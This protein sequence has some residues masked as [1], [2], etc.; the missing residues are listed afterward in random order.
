MTVAFDAFSTSGEDSDDL[1]WTHTPSGTPKGVTVEI[2]Q[3]DGADDQVSGVTY[4]AVPMTRQAFYNKG[5]AGQDNDFAVYIYSL[6]SSVPT[7]AQ[8][9]AV[10]RSATGDFMVGYART[11]TT[12]SGDTE[13]VDVDGLNSSG[14]AG[15]NDSTLNLGGKTC[16]V[17]QVCSGGD[18]TSPTNQWT[19]LTGWTEDNETYVDSD[20]NVASFSYDT[21]GSSDVTFGADATP[22]TWVVAAI[23]IAEA[24][25]GGG[26]TVAATKTSMSLA[27][28][29]GFT[30][31]TFPATKASASLTAKDADF[32]YD[33]TAEA[34][35]AA[36]SISPR[37]AE[38]LASLLVN[39][40]KASLTLTAKDAEGQTN[41]TI[42]AVKQTLSLTAKDAEHSVTVTVAALKAS[43]SLIGKTGSLAGVVQAINSTFKRYRRVGR[44]R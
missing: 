43:L 21:I 1:S 35:K 10:T 25:A 17:S 42:D 8:T 18:P 20:D 11:Y 19:P 33:F 22:T 31:L 28:K 14:S 34:L 40:A 12:A 36:V 13:V 2:A 30:N 38:T 32:I 44:E 24:A 37:D 27:A 15:D 3:T 23:A 26:L 39:A 4:G 6:T 41:I 7:G 9:V 29:T 5:Q 16:A